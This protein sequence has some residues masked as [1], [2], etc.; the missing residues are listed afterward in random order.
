MGSTIENWWFVDGIFST[1]LFEDKARIIGEAVQSDNVD[2][3][4]RLIDY[5]FT[6]SSYTLNYIKSLKINNYSTK[7]IFSF[8]EINNETLPVES[9]VCNL[10]AECISLLANGY[11]PFAQPILDAGTFIQ[12]RDVIEQNYYTAYN[13][14]RNVYHAAKK[15]LVDFM[16]NFNKP[17]FNIDKNKIYLLF[18][19]F[20]VSL[21]YANVFYLAYFLL[22]LLSVGGFNCE[23]SLN[24]SF[25]LGRIS[26]A[27]SSAEY[28]RDIKDY[29]FRQNNILFKRVVYRIEN[30]R[31]LFDDI[32]KAL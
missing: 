20:E 6:L 10:E 25:E 15:M 4:Y 16:V 28:I 18:K 30:K 12:N 19:E 9:K 24:F 27:R 17:V 8:A 3:V 22:F 14:R 26:N 21:D 7:C 32:V 11:A 5:S 23:R 29:V 31:Q 13:Q 1:N 2:F